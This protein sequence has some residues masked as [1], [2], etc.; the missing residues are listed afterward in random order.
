MSPELFL[1]KK[2]FKHP[3]W[4]F[5][6]SMEVFLWIFQYIQSICIR[7]SLPTVF[8]CQIS[9]QINHIKLQLRVNIN[10]C[11]LFINWTAIWRCIVSMEAPMRTLSYNSHTARCRQTENA[12]ISVNEIVKHESISY[13]ISTQTVLPKKKK[14]WKKKERQHLKYCNK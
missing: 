10:I 12:M 7:M 14:R 5:R 11:T 4:M 2:Y 6:L 1:Q 9:T 13:S 3:L 8:V